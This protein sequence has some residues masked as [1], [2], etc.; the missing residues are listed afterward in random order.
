MSEIIHPIATKKTIIKAVVIALLTGGLLLI[1]AV[2]PAE[3]GIDPFG[4][5]KLFGFSR[6]YVSKDSTTNTVVADKIV[7]QKFPLIK[8]EEAGSDPAIKKP[9][10]ANNPAPVK[11]YA[12]REDSVQVIVKAGKGIEYKVKMLKYGSMKYEWT[13]DHGTL[14]F[15]FH[16]EVKEANSVK[17]KE[18]FYESYTVAYSNNM[19]GTFLA[20]FE[21][22]HGWYF[23]N[24]GIKDILVTLRLKGQYIKE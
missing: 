12:Q 15:D 16:G 3:Y 17:D 20:P 14:F 9:K 22:R 7:Q 5:G 6:L 23:R 10:E 8:M 11:Q 19:V 24:K 1:T 4:T 2:L 18:V 21:G 13:A